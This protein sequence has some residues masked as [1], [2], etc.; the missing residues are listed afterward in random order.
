MKVRAV[1]IGYYKLLRRYPGDE[2]EVPEN[3]YSDKWMEKV[4]GPSKSKSKASA[5][6]EAKAE[7]VDDGEVI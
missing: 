1:K 2:F 7:S 6:A 4:D 3:M 5:K